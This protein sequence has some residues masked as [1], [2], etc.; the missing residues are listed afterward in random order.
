MTADPDVTFRKIRAD[1]VQPG[2][3]VSRARSH[4][5][6]LVTA[7]EQLAETTRIHRTVGADDAYNYQDIMRPRH[8]AVVWVREETS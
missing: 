4:S 7:T 2:M 3:R 6:H 8:G 1:E 5:F